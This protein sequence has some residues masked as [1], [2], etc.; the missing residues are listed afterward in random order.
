MVERMEESE[1][2]AFD[3]SEGEAMREGTER[4]EDRNPLD[5]DDVRRTIFE[6]VQKGPVRIHCGN[7]RVHA[8]SD[9]L[10]SCAQIAAEAIVALRLLAGSMSDAAKMAYPAGTFLKG[11]RPLFPLN[12]PHR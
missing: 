11:E 7:G 8:S 12:H 4:P 5:V 3:P 1:S 9:P 10:V 2:A 6:R